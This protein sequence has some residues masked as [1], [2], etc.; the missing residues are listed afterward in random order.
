MLNNTFRGGFACGLILVSLLAAGRAHALAPEHEVRRLMLATEEAVA[1]E[2]WG[3]AGEYLNRLQTLDAS[4]PADYLFFRGRVMYQSSHFNE[5]R[6]ALERYISEVGSKGDHYRDALQLLTAVEKARKESASSAQSGG[7]G[8]DQPVAVIEPAGNETLASLR[9]LYLANSDSEALVM[10]VNSLLDLAGW[11]ESQNVLMLDTPPDIS[12]RVAVTGDRIQIQESRR[13]S[14]NRIDKKT[15]S[16]EVFG[17]N[18][19]VRWDCEPTANACWIYDPRN[20]SRLMQLA[21]ESQRAAKIAS[22]LG[23]LIR[24]LQTTE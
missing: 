16:I 8:E 23:R 12:Y 18:P 6:S 22:N 15:E 17:V 1:A 14:G 24:T 20:G 11:R 4:K 19:Q 9:Q 3:E 7:N 2:Q 21:N 5:A 13:T 10:H